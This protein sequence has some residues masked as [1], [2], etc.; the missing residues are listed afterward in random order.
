MFKN[1]FES[2]TRTRMTAG[3]LALLVGT[4]L[5]AQA[6]ALGGDDKTMRDPQRNDPQRTDAQ[7]GRQGSVMFISADKLTGMNVYDLHDETLGSISELAIDRGSGQIAYLVL[8][9][10]SALGG[11]EV[12]V[13]YSSF[14]WD[15]A[16]KHVILNTTEAELKTHSEF[17]RTRWIARNRS[18][19]GLSQNLAKQYYQGWTSD[20]QYPKDM[21]RQQERQIRGRVT[22][23]ER[24]SWDGGPEE[25]VVIVTGDDKQ[26]HRVAVG[27]SW[28]LAGNS[29]QF[30]RENPVDMQVVTVDRN[31]RQTMV[32]RS[33]SIN[34]KRLDLYDK[35][36]DA[37]WV[38]TSNRTDRDQALLTAPFILSTDLI[39]KQVQCRGETCGEV[40]DLVV[41]CK[42]GQ[43]AFLS[44]DPD[45][46]ALGIG[47]TN[48]LVPWSVV[49]GVQSDRVLVDAA[50]SMVVQAKEAPSDLKVLNDWYQDAYKPYD[51]QAP[52][53]SPRS[54]QPG[55]MN[56]KTRRD[57]SGSRTPG[58][59]P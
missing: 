26:E 3:A 46:N 22:G 5:S 45:Q 9:T 38:N 40:D 42:S 58:Q 13:P 41:E 17:D 37:Y 12:A 21:S 28:Y 43:V 51:M 19:E 6:L 27:P 44:I 35:E 23:F 52:R 8:R 24:Q 59:R 11:K 29:V 36:G 57:D 39:G 48:R 20:S 53:Y 34:S 56:D 25:L 47:D 54:R 18:E 14:T 32:A 30:Y 33:A 55:N 31:G 16:D 49:M 1:R 15:S 50:K 4:A 10:G 2:V 7:R